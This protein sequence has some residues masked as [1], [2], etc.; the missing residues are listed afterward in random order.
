MPAGSNVTQSN[1]RDGTTSVPAAMADRN[2]SMNSQ[3]AGETVPMDRAT[4]LYQMEVD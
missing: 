3:A 1:G 4:R 2:G